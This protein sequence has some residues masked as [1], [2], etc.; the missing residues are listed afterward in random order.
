MKF[1]LKL[2]D[3][4]Q[5]DEARIQP[6]LMLIGQ[7]DALLDCSGVDELTLDQL[8]RIFSAVPPEWDFVE[9]GEVIDAET[10]SE[11]FA[12]QLE[13]WVNQR[14]G[15]T[16]TPEIELAEPTE[17][18]PRPTLDIFNL[19]DEVIGDYREYIESFL[20]IRDERVQ[21]FVH[22][23]LE[24]GELWP[25]PL[26]QLNPSYQQGVNIP[27]LVNQ[28]I[29]HPNCD[30]YFPDYV[31]KY[32]FR[33]HQEQAFRIAHRQE[34]YVLTTGTGSGKS[35]TYVVPIFDDLLRNPSLQGVRAILVYPMNA[36]INSQKEEFDKFLSQ[37]PGSH[38]RVEQYTGQESLAKKV[39][40]QNNPPQII[41]TNYMML[42]LMLSRNQE[43]KLVASPDLKF[44]VLDELHT[45][46]GRQGADVAILIRKL[47]QRCGQHLLCIGTSATMSTEGTRANRKQTV[48]SVASKL[49]GVE[50]MADNVIDET[51]ERSIQRSEPTTTELQLAI[52]AGLPPE[53]KQTPEAFQMHSL[54]VWM[55]MTFGL[56]EEEG[57]LIRRTPI[58]LVAGAAQ[59]AAQT[60]TEPE[61]CLEILRQMFLWGS[62][63]KGLAF[64]LH[65]FISQG[66]SVYA[67]AEKRENRFLTLEGQYS[68]TGDRCSIPWY[69]VGSAART[70][71]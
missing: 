2:Q 24:Q 62:K 69:F 61:R 20:K 36:L 50:V 59:L 17:E 64:R 55:E 34:P 60:Q 38:I 22:E 11:T 58:S 47:R 66:G 14:Q 35:M 32:T 56:Q 40:I 7:G 53:D 18:E 8:E 41:L 16:S 52:A 57:Q 3:L 42:E 71:T 39:E 30:R 26:V 4:L 33:L 46:R 51:L 19:R 13:Q 54:A 68:T 27:N 49:F 45:Y 1:P 67:T 5:Q 12:A 10:L 37:V 31:S 43:E 48:A 28:G 6:Y 25:D 23:G 9:L 44:L 21:A 29:L 15:R 65:Q 63:T 70:I